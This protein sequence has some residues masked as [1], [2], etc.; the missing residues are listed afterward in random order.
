MATAQITLDAELFAAAH[1]IAKR[2]RDRRNHHAFAIRKRIV[3][4]C[5]IYPATCEGRCPTCG[6]SNK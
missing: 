1:R 5:A 6:W 4:R 3:T 2:M